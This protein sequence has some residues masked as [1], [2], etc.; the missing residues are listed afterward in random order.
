MPEIEIDINV[1]GVLPLTVLPTSVD[2]TILQGAGRLAGWSLRDASTTVP[3][4]ASGSVVAPIAAAD[5]VALSGL[6]GG[7]Y[8]VE[9]AVGLQGAAAAADANNF[10]LYTTVGNVLVSINPGVAG[11]YPQLNAEVTIT[12]GGK[13][14]VKAIGAG[15]AGVTYTADL[16]I[17]PT[18][19]IETIAELQD[20]AN[21]LGEISPASHLSQTAWF[22]A[23]GPIAFGKCL[24]HVVSGTITG[25][26]YVVPSRGSQ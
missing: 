16:V 15:T 19:E 6:P 25:T 24:L 7:T 11:D 18:G 17:S 12:A 4:D 10:Q 22:G 23:S 2:V 1:G 21:V 9:W 8:T 3:Q 26:V 5:I 13:I 14:A 20:G